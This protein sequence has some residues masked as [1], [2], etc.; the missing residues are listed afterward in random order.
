LAQ[1]W[2]CLQCGGRAS[3]N[4]CENCGSKN[5][6]NMGAQPPIADTKL[7][8][9]QPMIQKSPEFIQQNNPMYT[10]AKKKEQPPLGGVYK[11]DEIKMI[12]NEEFDEYSD[13]NDIDNTANDLEIDG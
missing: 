4:G 9:N 11:S 6:R 13:I 2:V 3:Q 7:K 12:N 10:T 8:H 5:V 1:S